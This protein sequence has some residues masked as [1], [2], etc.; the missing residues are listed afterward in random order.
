MITK[1]TA[2]LPCGLDMEINQGY[3]DADFIDVIF[4]N[5]YSPKLPELIDASFHR[6]SDNCMKIIIYRGTLPILKQALDALSALSSESLNVVR[7]EPVKIGQFP[8]S[9]LQR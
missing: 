9:K 3:D 5:P 7:L 2:H 6:E 8:V 4:T 1:F